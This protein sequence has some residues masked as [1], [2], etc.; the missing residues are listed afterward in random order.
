MTPC[1]LGKEVP[2]P[3]DS[4]LISHVTAAVCSCQQCGTFMTSSQSQLIGYRCLIQFNKE[5]EIARHTFSGDHLDKIQIDL[6][7]PMRHFKLFHINLNTATLKFKFNS[8]KGYRG[9]ITQRRPTNGIT[10]C[11]TGACAF[12]ITDHTNYGY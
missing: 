9:R 6:F 10:S 3:L 7:Q 1:A 8:Q 12:Q 2:P 4:R 11:E 5:V